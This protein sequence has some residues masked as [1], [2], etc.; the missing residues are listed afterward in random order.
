MP[1]LLVVKTKVS[2]GN[3]QAKIRFGSV[4]DSILGA[5]VIVWCKDLL[6]RDYSPFKTPWET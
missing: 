6:N 4:E 5:F 1:A 3:H 2:D